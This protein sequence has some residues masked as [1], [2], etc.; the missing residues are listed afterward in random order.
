MG[1]FDTNWI[2]EFEYSEG[3]IASYKKASMVV[4]ASSEF[5]AKDKAK[6]VLKNSYRFV[7]V[8]SAHKSSGRAEERNAS[9]IPKTTIVDKPKTVSQNENLYSSR[10]SDSHMVELTPE[11]REALREKRRI[12]EENR[13][14]REKELERNRK[15][16]QKEKELAIAK[17]LHI[18]AGILGAILSFS[19]F[20]FG[21]MP[22]WISLFKANVAKSQ[23]ET[24]IEL[25]HSESDATG[26]NYSANIAKYTEQAKSIIW[27]PFVILVV[28]IMVVV[29]LVILVKKQ[30]PSRVEK[31]SNDLEE[32]KRENN[33]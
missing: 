23:L 1:L 26:Q 4:E 17:R 24:W 14:K 19:V 31:I 18:R 7:R 25:G 20:L 21:W 8:L 12:D 3:L 2:V 13:I 32:L 27:L 15:I 28:A 9:F 6:S 5:D 22:C 29:I 33:N 10:S 11:E 16:S 30:E